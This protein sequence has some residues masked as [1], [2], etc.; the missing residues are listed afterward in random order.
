MIYTNIQTLEE[1]FKIHNQQTFTS[2]FY[3][4]KIEDIFF[5]IL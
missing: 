4:K 2:A 5:F 3:V 1:T